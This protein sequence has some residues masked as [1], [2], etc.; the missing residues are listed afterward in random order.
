MIQ[1]FLMLL[2]GHALEDFALKTST[3]AQGKNRHNK[4][5]NVPLKQK[6]TPCWFYF[7][8]AHALI[9]GGTVWLIIGYWYFA[10]AE[11]VAHWIIDF[12]KCEN[13]LNP[14]SDQ[15]L[16]IVCKVAWVVLFTL[17]EA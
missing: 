5:V 2:I 8:T 1:L 3:T 13:K 10:I 17:I 11:I 7:L 12:A 9:H 15:F 4:P 14:H 16:H 6:V